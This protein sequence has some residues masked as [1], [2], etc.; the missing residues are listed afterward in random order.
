MYDGHNMPFVYSILI[1]VL[2]TIITTKLTHIRNSSSP[3][4]L[5]P[6]KEQQQ[7]MN[8]AR[9]SATMPCVRNIVQT[10]VSYCS[11]FVASDP[12]GGGD[13]FLCSNLLIKRSCLYLNKDFQLPNVI[14]H[15]KH[16]YDGHNMTFLICSNW[17]VIYY[18]HVERAHLHKEFQLGSHEG[19]E[20]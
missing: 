13:I 2:F 11:L 14:R 15:K 3:I 18:H 1:L 5:Q 17:S 12:L 19:Q 6:N 4:L 10:Q 9:R 7:Q 16:T 20:K 8:Y